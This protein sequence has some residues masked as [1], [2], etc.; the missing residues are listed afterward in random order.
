ME[1][2]DGMNSRMPIRATVFC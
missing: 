2:V 1:G